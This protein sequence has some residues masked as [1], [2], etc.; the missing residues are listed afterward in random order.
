[1]ARVR[2]K[3]TNFRPIPG[4]TARRYQNIK[5]GEIVSLREF[6]R[7]AQRIEVEPRERKPRENV[8]KIRARWYAN[9]VNRELFF[10]QAPSDA[11]ISFE[12]AMASPEF[13]FYEDMVHSYYP[14]D[15]S[16]GWEFWNDLA[17]Y[18]DEHSDDWGETP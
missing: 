16:L 8:R 13:I 7:R 15:R 11:Y 1:M 14:D 18:Y 12:Q 9:K 10:E 17:D 2:L 5:T 4:D 3:L 6:Q